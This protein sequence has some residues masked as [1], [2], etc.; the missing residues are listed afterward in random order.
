MSINIFFICCFLLIFLNFGK[1]KSYGL[2][3]WGVNLLQIK[4]WCGM[5]FFQIRFSSFLE[6]QYAFQISNTGD[7]DY[8]LV[9][10]DWENICLPGKNSITNIRKITCASYFVANRVNSCIILTWNDKLN[11][12]KAGHKH[13]PAFFCFFEQRCFFSTSSPLILL[14][15]L[16]IV[17]KQRNLCKVNIKTTCDD[18]TK[19]RKHHSW[20]GKSH[21]PLPAFQKIR[22]GFPCPMA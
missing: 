7:D 16:I 9:F 20:Q 18:L 14:N 13:R 22:Y 10:L 3:K 8:K 19:C 2:K 12:Q 21:A 15:P 11:W 1:S 5:I 4:V 6:E 17:E